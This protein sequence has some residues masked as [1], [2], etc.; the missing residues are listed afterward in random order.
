MS[1]R[2]ERVTLGS[3][4]SESAY[5]T[6]CESC[7]QVVAQ[8]TLE[9]CYTIKDLGP[10]EPYLL[11]AKEGETVV[12]I[13]PAYLYR[14]PLGNIL[15][16]VPQPGPLGG[17]SADPDYP[18]R[19]LIYKELLGAMEEVARAEGCITM[20][21]ITSPFSDDRELYEGCGPW[22]FTL[23]NFCQAIRL[24]EFFEPDGTVAHRGYHRR[25]SNLG[26]N[27]AKARGSALTVR[28]TDDDRTL[29]VWW[30][31]HR[32]RFETIGARP[33]P[34]ELFSSFRRW[35]IHGGKGTFL[36]AFVEDTLVGGAWYVHHDGVM[37]SYMPS[38]NEL[39][40]SLGAYYLIAEVSLHKARDLGV[41]WY[42]WQSSS[43]RTSGVYRFK[44]QWGSHDLTYAFLTRV[45]GDISS[46]CEAQEDEVRQAYRWHYVLPFS[47]LQNRLAAHVRKGEMEQVHPSK[48]G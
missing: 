18:D 44:A 46:L 34:R 11:M 31:I 7:P 43:S 38:A 4:A 40:L 29:D 27:M 3:E 48:R 28:E 26:R 19:K 24:E 5:R 14:H 10:D 1:L 39:G 33:L 20:T 41:K 8:Q 16:S 21:V 25:S 22:E 35:M 9:W 47:V 6:F 30:E 36:G 45:V 17:V 32:E 42:N 23:E 2:V 12:G 13:L 15:T 37:D